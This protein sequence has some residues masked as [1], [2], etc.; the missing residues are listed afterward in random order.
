MLGGFAYGNS[1]GTLRDVDLDIFIYFHSDG[2]IVTN[3][4]N[5]PVT[6]FSMNI[7]SRR[8]EV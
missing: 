4:E 3:V 7:V 2:Y 8:L 1:I 6:S 5:T